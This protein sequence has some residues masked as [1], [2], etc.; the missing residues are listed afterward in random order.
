MPNNLKNNIWASLGLDKFPVMLAPLAGVSDHPFRRIAQ[1]KGADLSYVEMLSATAIK[2]N[3]R[4]TFDMMERHESE[5]IL[6]VQVTGRSAEDVADAVTV[7]DRHHFDTIDIN[8]GCPVQKVVKAGCG[9]AIL[10]DPERVYQ[11]TK[12]A[13]ERTSKP[14]SCKIRLGWDKDSYTYK[15]VAKAVEEAGAD[16]ITVHGRLRSDDY[17]VPVDLE[18]IREIKSLL[19]IPV[20]GNGNIFSRIDV[21][22]MKMHTGI[23]GVMVSRGA[24][25][26]PWVFQDIKHS[27]SAVSL[28]DW[29]HTVTSHLRYQEGAYGLN[30]RSAVCMRKHLLWYIKGWPGAKKLRSELSSVSCLKTA[31]E[32]VHQFVRDLTTQGVTLRL[33]V[34]HD[35]PGERFSYDPKYDMDRKLDR[36]VGD[37]A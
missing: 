9:S 11:T 29:H 1:E 17:S 30:S 20:I 18:R 10:L 5:K 15:D 27:N 25:G 21:D 24:L 34:T 7:L 14:L 22:H 31:T 32:L 19:K 36:G 8:M 23:D 6:G 26:N 4:Q 37:E 13:R 2:F 35:A 28:A 3:S 12:M 33:P 16:W